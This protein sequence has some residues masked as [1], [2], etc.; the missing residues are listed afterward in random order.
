MRRTTPWNLRVHVLSVALAGCL[1]DP[2]EALPDASRDVRNEDT[3]KDSPSDTPTDTP[4]DNSGDSPSDNP[5]DSPSDAVLDAPGDVALDAR[6]AALDAPTDARDAALD[7]PMDARDASNDVRDASDV[8][9]FGNPRCA[10]SGFAICEDFE[11]D[12]G[13]DRDVWTQYASNGTLA[14][15][16]TRAARGTHAL[17]VHTHAP[18]VDGGAG[19]NVGLRTVRGF[20]PA[21]NTYF[22][23][24]FVWMAARS[25]TTHSTLFE[26]GGRIVDA[27][28]FDGSLPDGG[29]NVSQ[30][31]S[32]S[33]HQLEASYDVAATAT[34]ARDAPRAT[35]NDAL[36]DAGVRR[37]EWHFKGDTN[38]LHFWLDGVEL[39]DMSVLPTRVPTWFAP[40]W[41]RVNVGL[42]LYR[43]DAVS[44]FDLWIDEVAINPTRVGCSR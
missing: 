44:D 40:D 20:P 36:D 34:D 7:A 37:L 12:A 13:Y 11:G 2:I 25:P 5:S 43:P 31:F 32:I 16:T 9:Y 21:R 42:Q 24:A 33:G 39:T 17:H 14:I 4:G 3:P 35:P 18:D 26:S 19:A 8:G 23:R 38:E 22:G 6:D 41:V 1:E 10:D 15:E 27:G 29:L 28:I 30:R